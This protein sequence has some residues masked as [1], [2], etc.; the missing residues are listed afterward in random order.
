M[1][2]RTTLPLVLE[3]PWPNSMNTHWRSM[4]LPNGTPVKYISEAGKKYRKAV[5]EA[6]LVQRAPVGL[7]GPLAVLVEAWLPDRRQRDLDNYLKPL[8]DAMKT[9]TRPKEM[10][11]SVVVDDSQFRDI[12]I[13]DR[14]LAPPGRILVTITRFTDGPDL[15]LEQ[16]DGDNAAGAT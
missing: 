10:M 1:T 3:L 16:D 6:C 15:A 8:F 13:V 5:C 12:R 11:A 9:P 2:S 7:H 4:N 14:G